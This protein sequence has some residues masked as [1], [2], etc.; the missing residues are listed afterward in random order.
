[1]TPDQNFLNKIV[2]VIA[3]D[4]LHNNFATITV[5]LLKSEAKTIDQIQ[6][7]L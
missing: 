1:M 7:I 2:I 5:S 6:N 4:I 3:L